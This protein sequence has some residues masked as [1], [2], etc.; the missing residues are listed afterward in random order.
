MAKST[1]DLDMKN[2]GMRVSRDNAD[3][4]L[5]YYFEPNIHTS[6]KIKIPWSTALLKNHSWAWGKGHVFLKQETRQAQES[7]SLR[8]KEAI[9]DHKFFHNKIWIDIYVQ[10]P[11]NRAG[12]AINFVD[13]VCDSIKRVVGVDD[14]WFCIRRVDW[15]ISKVNPSI[16]IGVSQEAVEDAS[17]C[18]GCGRILGLQLFNR[19]SRTLLGVSRECKE[20]SKPMG[21]LKKQQA[22]EIGGSPRTEIEI[23]EI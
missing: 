18:S 10:K 15:Q 19:N 20:C 7:L 1:K 21:K 12:D 9:G 14:R 11:D 17:V 4:I 22:H 8:I 6:I 13:R 5:D 2:Y 3:S 16:I 23:E